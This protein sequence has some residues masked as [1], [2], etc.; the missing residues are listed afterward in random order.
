MN[1][2]SDSIILLD[3]SEVSYSRDSPLYPSDDWYFVPPPTAPGLEDDSD[4]QT[5]N[6]MWAA[7]TPVFEN[8]KNVCK[9]ILT[10]LTTPSQDK[11]RNPQQPIFMLPS[12]IANYRS[13]KDLEDLEKAHKTERNKAEKYE[14]F[15]CGIDNISAKNSQKIATLPFLLLEDL[16]E[17]I[18]ALTEIHKDFTTHLQT[19]IPMV[20]LEEEGSQESERY[21][22]DPETREVKGKIQTEENKFQV[23]E[24]YKAQAEGTCELPYEMIEKFCYDLYDAVECTFASSLRYS[25][26]F[27]KTSYASYPSIKELKELIEKQRDYQ[28]TKIRYSQ[29][30]ADGR[31][32]C[33]ILETYIESI[34]MLIEIETKKK[35]LMKNLET[36]NDKSS[37]KTM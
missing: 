32:M 18:R 9:R 37:L 28:Q 21:V 5:P 23:L 16:A 15:I 10:P 33:A 19:M 30:A 4:N 27:M 36:I 35:S 14:E 34:R 25:P 1:V 24:N 20:P 7:L 31:Q 3:P 8:V 6:R 26:E 17:C 11:T 22:S 2:D 12:K 29:K 13:P